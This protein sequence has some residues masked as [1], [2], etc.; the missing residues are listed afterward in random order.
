MATR[1]YCLGKE[2]LCGTTRIACGKAC[3]QVQCRK[4]VGEHV[5]VGSPCANAANWTVHEKLNKVGTIFQHYKESLICCKMYETWQAALLPLMGGI[6]CPCMSWLVYRVSRRRLKRKETLKSSAHVFYRSL[7]GILLAQFLCHTFLPSILPT[8]VTPF[9]SLDI[10]YMFYFIL[11]GYF[12]FEVC[13]S[14]SRIWNTNV[15][16]ISPLDD[17]NAYGQDEIGLNKETMEEQS[18]VVGQNV[19]SND[20]S[21]TVWLLQDAA[22]DKRKRQWLLATLL[23][24]FCIISVMDGMLLVYRNP[25][26]T[27]QTIGIL[28]SFF[29]N[30]ISMSFAI[31]GGMIHAKFHVTEEERPRVLWWS[32]VT[33][34]WSVALICSS[35]PVLAGIS[36]QTTQDI[37]NNKILL[38]FY[39]FAAG[40]VLKL[41][42]YYH[43]Q[44]VND[45]DR[46]QTVI[47]LLVFFVALAQG[48]ATSLWL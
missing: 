24:T 1:N 34:V 3:E 35:I 28:V 20:F 16:Y 25:Q 46:R 14:I 45:I 30:G 13:E 32:F 44:K 37:V 41:Q 7:S 48:V 6:L 38:A 19:S 29:I 40:M 10:K 2:A 18:V 11:L 8:N 42:Q 5:H 17:A 12:V 4:G 33:A 36:L 31:F 27:L 39:G 26:D 21:N 23:V 43:Q 47:G 22:K 15:Q 9:T